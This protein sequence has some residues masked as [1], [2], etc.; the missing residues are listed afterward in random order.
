MID[1][2]PR[3]EATQHCG[4]A[5]VHRSEPRMKRSERISRILLK[6]IRLLSYAMMRPVRSCFGFGSHEMEGEVFVREHIVNGTTVLGQHVRVE[7]E[8]HADGKLVCNGVMQDFR[9]PDLVRFSSLEKNVESD[10]PSSSE[11][12][13]EPKSPDNGDSKRV[14]DVPESRKGLECFGQDNAGIDLNAATDEARVKL[15]SS[16]SQVL[17]LLASKTSQSCHDGKQETDLEGGE[18]VFSKQ[19]EQNKKAGKD[20]EPE[21]VLFVDPLPE[22]RNDTDLTLLGQTEEAF[23]EMVCSPIPFMDDEDSDELSEE[24]DP[25]LSVVHLSSAELFWDSDHSSLAGISTFDNDEWD[26]DVIVFCRKSRLSSSAR[27]KKVIA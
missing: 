2:C 14:A 17:S 11:I 3:T 4:E 26:E 12:G 15:S 18:H 27:Q 16:E 25:S 8:H 9:Q 6:P 21:P 10:L 24:V 5:E 22:D 19:E 7:A 1:T 20:C 13:D 23:L